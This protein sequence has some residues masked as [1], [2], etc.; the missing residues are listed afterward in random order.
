LPRLSPDVKELGRII[1]PATFGAGIYQ[2]SQFVDIFFATR[3]P[4]G[5]LAYLNYADRLNQLPLGVIGI[6]LGTA[7]LPSL[8]RS[9][10]EA[11]EAGAARVQGVALEMAM[12]LTLPAAFALAICAEPLVTAFFAGGRF[13]G[14]DA[15]TTG[16]VLAALV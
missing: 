3:L 5:S 14:G 15:A 16:A 7:I 9:I 12:L 6:A 11:D 10:A 2:L 1:L 4:Q 8:A 13:T